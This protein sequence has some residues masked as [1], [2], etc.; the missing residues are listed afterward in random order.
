[1][2][3][4]RKRER[5]L[6]VRQG[7]CPDTQIG[8]SVGNRAK[9]V[10]DGP[11]DLVDEYLP[12]LKLLTVIAVSAMTAGLCIHSQVPLTRFLGGCFVLGKQTNGLG[13]HMNGTDATVNLINIFAPSTDP[14]QSG[15]LSSCP[16]AMQM[17]ELMML[18]GLSTGCVHLY[19]I[20]T[21]IHPKKQSTKTSGRLLRRWVH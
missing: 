6:L 12:E 5:E 2:S 11:D 3:S 16:V 13:N 1:M 15:F 17:S 8:C 19:R 4:G 9:Y 10:L 18:G 20:I 7:Q 21:S 14:S